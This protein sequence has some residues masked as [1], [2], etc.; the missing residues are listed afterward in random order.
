MAAAGDVDEEF[1]I[2][3][4]R[5][6]SLPYFMRKV[7]AVDEPNA[8]NDWNKVLIIAIHSIMLELGFVLSPL[9]SSSSA[10][11]KGNKQIYNRF[12]LPH[13]W[14]SVFPETC[15]HYTLPSMP[16]TF[17]SR[18]G[19]ATVPTVVL[20][21]QVIGK[22]VIVYGSPATNGSEEV[23]RL[24]LDASRFVPPINFT[25]ASSGTADDSQ[26]RRKEEEDK[27]V[28]TYPENEIYELRRIVKDKI[29]LPLKTILC[30]KRGLKAPTS[31]MALPYHL[32]PE[33]LK[34]LSDADKAKVSC[35]CWELRRLVMEEKNGHDLVGTSSCPIGNRRAS[36]DEAGKG[37]RRPPGWTVCYSYSK[38]RCLIRIR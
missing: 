9:H 25:W 28:N 23:Y 29:G 32:K 36:A 10:P 35:V 20:K 3:P 38:F 21:F 16:F 31:F 37:Q 6:F 2:P 7:F 24:C 13:G 33:I 8:G 30:E 1:I 15:L 26:K 22:F 4:E 5:T 19:F 17:Y 34:S 14:A 12:R 27:Y 11:V 18:S